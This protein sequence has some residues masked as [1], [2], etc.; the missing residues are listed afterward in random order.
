[1]GN[2]PKPTE[3]IA[4]LGVDTPQALRDFYTAPG[5]PADR[6]YGNKFIDF[7][8]TPGLCRIGLMTRKSLANDAGV[9]A[10]GAGFPGG[11]F[12]HHVET[13][14]EVNALL[15]AVERAGGKIIEVAGEAGEGTGAGHFADPAGYLWKVHAG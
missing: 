11:V 6:D 1:M 13:R 8:L 2:P 10:E 9:D 7:Q 15:A 5:M 3:T 12:H 14:E 4:I